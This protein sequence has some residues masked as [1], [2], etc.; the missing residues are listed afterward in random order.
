MKTIDFYNENSVTLVKRYDNADMS[1]LHQLLLKYIPKNSSILDIG[2]GSGRDVNFLH[3]QGYDVWG[4][5]P[6]VKFLENIKQ[7]FPNLIEH[8][9]RA[10]IPFDKNMMGINREFDAIISIAMWM[11][12]EYAQYADAVASIVSVA[13]NNSNIVISFSIGN[14]IKDDRYFEEVNLTYLTELF[15]ERG[16]SL[17]ET[18]K[19]NDS[20][21]R[22][23]LTW[24]T[25][26]FKH[27]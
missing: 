6:S 7:V 16:F 10:S 15:K 22:D 11:H 2:F 27:D 13:N 12:L 8:F 14:R 21:G 17:V 1:S 3:N 23:I 24:I 18:V 9:Y 25:V 20:L 5:D 19:N 26:V 4:I